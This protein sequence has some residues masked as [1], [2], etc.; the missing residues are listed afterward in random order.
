MNNNYLLL[1]LSRPQHQIMERYCKGEHHEDVFS[2]K[3]TNVA[4]SKYLQA[5]LAANDEQFCKFLMLCTDEV[6]N[7]S[8]DE[9]G[10]LT[11]VACYKQQLTEQAKDLGIILEDE[12]FVE[13]PYEDDETSDVVTILAPIVQI[14]TSIQF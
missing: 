6:R 3:Q 7:I 1:M 2:G 5:I 8:Y 9:F 10:G 11:T 12:T 4:P 14:F 13:I